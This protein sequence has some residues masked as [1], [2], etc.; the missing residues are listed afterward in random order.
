MH[1]K[2]PGDHLHK[3]AGMLGAGSP[4]TLYR[5]LG[6]LWEN[7]A[8]PVPGAHGAAH[9]ALRPDPVARPAR[10]PPAHNVSLSDGVS[11]VLALVHEDAGR[12]RQM[13]LKAG[14]IQVRAPA[15]D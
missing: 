8:T 6:S 15:V 4:E 14:A 5:G 11:L 9:A 13:A 3:L 7:S 2:H 12:N 1:F 10:L